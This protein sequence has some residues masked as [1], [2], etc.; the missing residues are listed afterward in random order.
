MKSNKGEIT[1]QL[2]ITVIVLIVLG[3]V[4]IFMLTGEN[5]LFLPKEYEK[6]QEQTNNIS[7]ENKLENVTNNTTVNENGAITVPM[8]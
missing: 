5:G 4:C 8:E 6:N 7:T 3:G 1:I 2:V